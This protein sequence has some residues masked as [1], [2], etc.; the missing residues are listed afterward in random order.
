MAVALL[1]PRSKILSLVPN[2]YGDLGRR[3]IR[4]ALKTPGSGILR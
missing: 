4:R 1:E 3:R 2:E